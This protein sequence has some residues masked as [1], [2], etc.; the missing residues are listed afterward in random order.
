MNKLIALKSEAERKK[1]KSG[2][3]FYDW[4]NS[5]F[6]LV[7]TAVIFLPLLYEGETAA[8]GGKI[9]VLGYEF[10]NTPL[11]NY[12]SAFIFILVC[13]LSPILSGVADYTGNKKFFLK[14]FCYLGS[15]ACIG[16]F[17]F[18]VHNPVFG[19]LCYIF[20][21]LGYWGSLVFYNSYL[22]DIA[23]SEEHDSL[24]AKGFSLGFIGG[25]VLLIIS[26]VIVTQHKLLGISSEMGIKTP[27]ILTGIWWIGFSQ[28]TYFRLPN[29][30]TG[31]KMKGQVLF[32]G[33]KEL[34]KTFKNL[35]QN[36]HL[37]HYLS[38]FFFY[39]MGVQTLL[40]AAVFFAAKAIDWPSKDEKDIGMIS[41]VIII[42]V[43]AVLGALGSSLL[44][45]KIGNISALKVVALLWIIFCFVG[46]S[47]KS[48]MQYLFYWLVYGT[49]HGCNICFIKIYLF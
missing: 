39:S 4:A 21:N 22:A 49:S 11:I 28:I 31:N 18:D 29:L 12:I 41:S 19:L 34:N 16:L 1:I 24:S 37:K 30:K 38:A 8:M 32:N 36:E 42:Q 3:A 33:Y 43:S 13:I 26:L 6:M 14:L 2:W 17:F 25:I 45:K 35:K 44:S 27:F 46:Y 20:A 23:P 47:I 5:A 48:P 9:I 40:I 10:A 15:I 7:V